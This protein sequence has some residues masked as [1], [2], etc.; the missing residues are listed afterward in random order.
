MEK[1]GLSKRRSIDFREEVSD[2]KDAEMKRRKF[3]AYLAPG[4]AEKF[5]IDLLKT[6]WTN[7][8]S[9][10]NNISQAISL[11]NNDILCNSLSSQSRDE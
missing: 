9:M 11:L 1:R 4:R 7:V 6:N 10:C 3:F 2:K 8:N 5:W